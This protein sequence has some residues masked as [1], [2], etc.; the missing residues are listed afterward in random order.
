MCLTLFWL[1][2]V[3]GSQFGVVVTG[4]FAL[5]VS[6]ST[7]TVVQGS[8]ATTTAVVTSI[9]NF[10]SPV[11]L[12]VSGLPSGAIA[13]FGTNPVT[14]PRGGSASSLLIITAVSS[15]PVATYPLTVTGS[16]GTASHSA[17]LALQVVASGP[18]PDFTLIVSPES[19]SMPQGSTTSS[20]V[21]VVS[22]NGFSSPVSLIASGL[23]PGLTMSFATN[24]VTP[25]A[26][27]SASS[28]VRVLASSSLRIGL[29]GITITGSSGSLTH[30]TGLTVIVSAPADFSITPSSSSIS[31]AQGSSGSTTIMIT[32]INGL[33]SPVALSTTWIGSPTGLTISMPSLVAPTTNGFA[34]AALGIAASS[35]A[36]VGSF[37]LRVTGTSG[38]L[39]HSVDIAV[40]VASSQ[41]DF[42]VTVSPGIVTMVHG[43]E[44]TTTVTVFSVG[45]FSSAVSLLA[46]NV[47]DG[48]VVVFGTNTI[49]PPVG[50]LASSILTV[51]ASPSAS[52]GTHSVTI[53]AVSGGC[54]HSVSLTAIVTQV[55]APDFSLSAA[56]SS[57]TLT[58]GSSATA[59]VAVLS[60]N[61]FNSAVALSGS[62]LT[63]APNGVTFTIPSPITP[64]SNGTATSTLTITTSS[65]APLGNFTI[66][67]TGTSG[68]LSHY[69]D[70]NVIVAVTGPTCVIATATYGSELAPEVEILRN[71]RDQMIMK[72]YAGSNFMIVFNA[73][74]YSFSPNVA[75]YIAQHSAAK[76]VMKA[77]LYPLLG[78]MRLGTVVFQS[79]SVSSEG[80]TI[81][82]G[83]VISSLIGE[84]Y[85]AIPM[86]IVRK[87][88]SRARSV[89]GRLEKILSMILSTAL[90]TIFLIDISHVSAFLMSVSSAIVVLATM[91][92]SGL[93][94]SRIIVR[95]TETGE[96]APR[97]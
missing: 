59:S 62:W 41:K 75:Q 19:V 14:P 78:I 8:S 10:S 33:S 82:A 56:P 7:I 84:A 52:T 29:Y 27:G 43:S 31:I 37:T 91:F 89:A 26:G 22:T 53:T 12:A 88:S 90:A 38:S 32:F 28:V 55:A 81:F 49:T 2:A 44:A 76:A 35:T 25:S 40:Q 87:I 63:S 36:S 13:G 97:T 15:V 94:V 4:D 58:Q 45:G 68:G 39:A 23:P 70:I 24:P 48:M 42:T 83:L 86:T 60:E 3:S 69:I 5:S 73:W 47:P 30:S 74:Y 50:G 46:S 67:I 16:N 96:A 95:V 65:S 61:E 1:S 34:S 9:I 6:P 17:S 93:M 85:L 18:P 21:T 51:A 57:L 92:M 64:L 54:V 79:T 72:T 11:T 77:A 66:R 80:A 71:F 20:T